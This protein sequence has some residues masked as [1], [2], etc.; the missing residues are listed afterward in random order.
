MKA[1]RNCALHLSILQQQS[2]TS[3]ELPMAGIK[4]STKLVLEEKEKK[5]GREQK[6]LVWK[7]EKKEDLKPPASNKKRKDATYD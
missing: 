4:A 5:G 1:M 6:N 2:K 7:F 3:G